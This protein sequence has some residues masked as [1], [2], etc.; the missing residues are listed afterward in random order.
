MTNDAIY[1]DFFNCRIT[2]RFFFTGQVLLHSPSLNSDNLKAI[3]YKTIQG[4]NYRGRV[5]IRHMVLDLGTMQANQFENQFSQRL[6]EA[7]TKNLLRLVVESQ[8]QS[9]S[10]LIPEPGALLAQLRPESE[11]LYPLAVL[12]LKPDALRQL[13][14]NHR[15]ERLLLLLKM[16]I[17]PRA[18]HRQ[19]V[20]HYVYSQVTASRL[21]IAALSFLLNDK[22]G[23]DWL[24][25]NAPRSEQL[26]A[27]GEAIGS[28]EIAA[29]QIVQLLTGSPPPAQNI[30]V[31]RHWLLALW[32]QKTVRN[33][34]AKHAGRAVVGKITAYFN[35]PG[36]HLQQP[37]HSQKPQH[38]QQLQYSQQP[39]QPQSVT[40]AGLVLLWPLLLQLFSLLDL[41]LDG[42]FT[43]DDARWQ[44]VLTL[45]WLVWAEA[46]APPA[47]ERLAIN[48]L[49]CGISVDTPLP[50]GL[51]LT[52]QRQQLV[53]DWLTAV[54]RQL[55]AWQKLALSDIRALFLQRPGEVVY[56]AE[57]PQII[58]RGE[59]FDYLLA[60]LPWPLTLVSLPWL[61]QPLTLI[62]PLPHLTG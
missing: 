43:D 52:L 31:T 61:E 8:S 19:R 55:P 32:Q 6:A 30:M 5:S 10:A 14:V 33:V 16:L 23:A 18:Q 57:P 45:N 58:V 49:L 47:A 40:N 48:C 3:F 17:I 26:N 36:T 25:D 44:A 2:T 38:A 12:C 54:G 27:W 9:T 42:K 51:S 34:V 24:S 11:S 62:W 22:E 28:G 29:E 59:A 37:Q 46:E 1:I 60:D 4:L 13:L 21:A 56:N 7:L 15:P 39:Q 35:Q 41:C 50:E 20:P 53:D